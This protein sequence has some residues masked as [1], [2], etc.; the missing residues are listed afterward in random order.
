MV[1]KPFRWRLSG[2]AAGIIHQSNMNQTT[3]EGTGCQNHGRGL[4]EQAVPGLDTGDTSTL[5][6]QPHNLGLLEIKARLGLNNQ[7]HPCTVEIAISLRP[8]SPNCWPLLSIK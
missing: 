6:Q 7:L 1:R 4:E 8:G 2:T 3:H 5:H